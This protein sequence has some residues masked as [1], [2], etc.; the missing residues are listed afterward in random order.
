ML[1]RLTIMTF[2]LGLVFVFASAGFA[3]DTDVIEKARTKVTTDFGVDRVKANGPNP[4]GF[5]KDEIPV[6]VTSN[7]EFTKA[8]VASP[9]TSFCEDQDRTDYDASW[10]YF[11][12]YAGDTRLLAGRFDVPAGHSA[13]LY[14]FWI[15]LTANP[16]RNKQ[17]WRLKRKRNLLL[18]H[19]TEALFLS[20]S[21]EFS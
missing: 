21:G 2:V 17:P 1:K 14:A 10:Y 9:D 16:R 13:D 3:G 15:W 8:S 6:P 20:R 11:S 4:T 12:R 5:F 7:L 19:N 18:E